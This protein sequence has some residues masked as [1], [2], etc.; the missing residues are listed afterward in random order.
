MSHLSSHQRG[1]LRRALALSAGIPFANAVVPHASLD[2]HQPA[3][4]PVI[5]VIARLKFTSDSCTGPLSTCW[6]HIEGVLGVLE[7]DNFADDLIKELWKHGFQL[8]PRN[9][10]LLGL[11]TESYVPQIASFHVN[12]VER[13]MSKHSTQ[14]LRTSAV[15]TTHAHRS[16]RPAR[17]KAQP[18][19]PVRTTP[20]HMLV[21]AIGVT[22]IAIAVVV[23]N[24]LGFNEGKRSAKQ[25][26]SFEESAPIARSLAKA[27]AKREAL[28]VQRNEARALRIAEEDEAK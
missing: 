11:Q 17:S 2:P 5:D 9:L 4:A 19:A 8:P 6:I 1:V 13:K 7:A 20:P 10:T 3:D 25:T 18:A 24:A 22:F 15:K 23:V 14:L 28:E 27:R 16:E 21:L 12:L 26:V